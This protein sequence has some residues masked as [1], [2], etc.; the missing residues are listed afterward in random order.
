MRILTLGAFFLVVIGCGTLIGLI[1]HPDE[2]YAGLAKA[3]FNPPDWVFAP[4]WTVLYV[5]IGVAGWRVWAR[6]G[7]H[8]TPMKLWI[9]QLALNFSW[10]PVFFG[11]HRP[12]AA[13]IIVVALFAVVVAFIAAAWPRERIAAWLFV[14]YAL[15][16]GFATSLNGAIV[17]LN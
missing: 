16:V 7:W 6:E 15:W 12:A 17:M 3:S 5:M 1:V 11:A 2:W 14:P 9:A 13:L 10:T 8:A 4:V